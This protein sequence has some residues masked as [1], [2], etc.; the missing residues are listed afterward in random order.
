VVHPL[1]AIN[2]SFPGG[3]LQ[4]SWPYGTLQEADEVSGPYIDLTDVS[5]FTPT[6]TAPRKF[7]RIRL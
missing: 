5:P 1:P 2:T 4:L 6:M 7:Y 3:Q